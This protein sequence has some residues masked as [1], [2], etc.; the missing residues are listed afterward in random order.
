MILPYSHTLLLL[1]ARSP[2][3]SIKP[4]CPALHYT[5]TTTTTTIMDT[6]ALAGLSTSCQGAL[7]QL[8]TSSF[9]TCADVFGLVQVGFLFN[10]AGACH[11]SCSVA[12]VSPQLASAS[13]SVVP[14]LDSYI[15]G[16]SIS[17]ARLPPCPSLCVMPCMPRPCSPPSTRRVVHCRRVIT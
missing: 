2:S 13:G 1:L 10:T 9:A 17:V 16:M 7:P 3:C 4:P 14:A 11:P 12:D 15:G 8:L 5:Y 6:S